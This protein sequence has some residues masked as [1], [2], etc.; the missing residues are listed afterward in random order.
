M[1]VFGFLA[2]I[3]LIPIFLLMFIS[4]M[5]L[6]AVFTILAVIIIVPLKI[7]YMVFIYPCVW[8]AGCCRYGFIS[9]QSYSHYLNL[10]KFKFKFNL[11]TKDPT[12]P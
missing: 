12:Y 6:T 9:F 11:F 7:F 10:F 8:L 2:M 3:V 5:I 4:I 1:S